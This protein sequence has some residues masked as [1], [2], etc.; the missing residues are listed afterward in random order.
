MRNLRAAALRVVADRVGPGDDYTFV[1]EPAGVGEAGVEEIP[2]DALA[3]MGGS[4]AGGAEEAEAAVVRLVRGEAGDLAAL[5]GMEEDAA[6]GFEAPDSAEVFFDE[7]EDGWP[8]A[9]GRWPQGA[10]GGEVCGLEV[11]G[12]CGLLVAAFQKE[13][14][15]FFEHA[16]R[17][18]V[19]GLGADASGAARLRVAQQRS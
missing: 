1:V 4:D 14:G 12:S 10:V 2:A 9:A 5:L 3:A 16:R 15:L 8:L 6:R 13:L 7:G 17:E 19:A 11:L 18:V